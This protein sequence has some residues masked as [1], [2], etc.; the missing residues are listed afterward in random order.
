MKSYLQDFKS[1]LILAVIYLFF[2]ATTLGLFQT[3]FVW[4]SAGVALA[5]LM[6]FGARAWKG[7]A[8]G[9]FITIIYHFILIGSPIFSGQNL[10]INLATTTGNTISALVAYH[11]INRGPSGGVDFLSAPSLAGRFFLCCLIMGWVSAVPGVGLY[12]ILG[13]PWIEGFLQ[14]AL[15]WSISN[16]VGSLLLT[17]AV[18]LLWRAWPFKFNTQQTWEG[19]Y[20]VLL[21]AVI[22]LFVFGPLFSRFASALIQP[23]FLLLPLLW[24]AVRMPPAMI[25]LLNLFA[26][27]CA[28]IG[29]NAGYGSFVANYPD[30]PETAMQFFFGFT[31]CAVLIVQALL[32]QRTR[33]QKKLTETLELKVAERTREYH[34]EIRKAEQQARTDALTG[35]YN[36]RGLFE[37]GNKLIEQSRRYQHN[38]SF[39][40]VDI[41]H[42]KQVNDSHGHS[43]GDEVLKEI[44]NAITGGAR[45]SDVPGR[46]GGEE[47]AIILPE[48]ISSVAKDLAERLRESISKLV[49]PVG[50]CELRLS[51]SFG[52]SEF[53]VD[54]I[55]IEEMMARA[56]V[57][58]YQAKEQ[59]RNTVVEAC[60]PPDVI[61]CVG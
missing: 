55:S 3:L 35:L 4:P 16:M 44:A 15:N 48:T 52:V 49:I 1:S 7:I 43:V 27:Y 2:S 28:W 10:A 38:C 14:G 39:I 9:S 45:I 40:M 31:I 18:Y 56:D 33:E 19:I 8:L 53:H 21:V 32:L 22:S 24:A 61:N 6:L 26:F 41:D 46:V 23:A 11:I 54:D 37:H 25:A 30:N 51:A 60:L 58:L 13:I 17:P 34:E 57:A 20:Q 47:F 50:D 42:F 36:R 59:G 12:F 5:G 29:T